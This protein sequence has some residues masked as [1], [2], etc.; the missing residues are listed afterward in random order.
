M[1]NEIFIN[2]TNQFIER[3]F[4][5]YNGRINTF[6]KAVL[7]IEWVITP[8]K[9]IGQTRNP[10]I[11]TIY[12]LVVYYIAQNDFMM[13]Y[14]LIESVIHEL[15]HV[16][17]V[18][19]YSKMIYDKQYV[20]V[21]ES[22]V[23]KETNIYI[24]NHYDEI[25]IMFDIDP[26]ILKQFQL[27]KINEFNSGVYIKRDYN[28][29][30]LSLVQEIMSIIPKDVESQIL[31]TNKTIILEINNE[32]FIL[33]GKGYLID[34]FSLNQIL[35]EKYFKYIIYNKYAIN[36]YITDSEIH[37]KCSVRLYYKLCSEIK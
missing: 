27:Y 36:Y 20:H 3:V 9:I 37:I 4:N 26:S 16:D 22:A 1:I 2:E 11:V 35:Y 8:N 12:P 18:I 24:I 6:N 7:K 21:I 19:D 32:S 10:N 17:Q 23:E 29:H 30:I 25:Q 28:T 31:E 15:H 13:K 33:R 14:L 5:Y 34:L